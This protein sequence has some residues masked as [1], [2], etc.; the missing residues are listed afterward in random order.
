MTF[1]ELNKKLG[2]NE[3][4]ADWRQHKNGGGWLNKTAKVARAIHSPTVNMAMFK[5]VAIVNRSSGG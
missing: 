2:G 1:A 3:K 5:S 4:S